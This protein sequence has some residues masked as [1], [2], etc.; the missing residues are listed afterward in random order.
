MKF[1]GNE[2][3]RWKWAIKQPYCK[4]LNKVIVFFSR[5]GSVISEFS[6]KYKEISTVE[7][8]ALA[9]YLEEKKLLG[10]MP[11]GYSHINT[12]QGMHIPALNYLGK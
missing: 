1:E 2:N 5:S 10:T 7:L 4:N 3:G 8:I 9:T 11:V 6:L 12:S